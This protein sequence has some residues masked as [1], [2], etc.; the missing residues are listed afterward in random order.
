MWDREAATE[1]EA[2]DWSL[3]FDDGPL[4]EVGEWMLSDGGGEIGRE[5]CPM[6][7]IECEEGHKAEAYGSVHLHRHVESG[8]AG[9]CEWSVVQPSGMP[10]TFVPS[11]TFPEVTL[12]LEGPGEYVIHLFCFDP[13]DL[14]H[15]LPAT[16]VV[17]VV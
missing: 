14:P 3:L 6:A 4:V 1:L 7:V 10:G 13:A 9:S 11:C 2:S 17:E 16:Y 15:C 5:A 8:P 12:F